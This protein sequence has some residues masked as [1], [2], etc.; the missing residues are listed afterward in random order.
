[1]SNQSSHPPPGVHVNAKRRL[2]LQEGEPERSQGASSPGRDYMRQTHV[3]SPAAAASPRTPS[4]HGGLASP[5]S[6][7]L[8]AAGSPSRVAADSTP[9]SARRKIGRDSPTEDFDGPTSGRFDTSL[10]ILTRKFV[11]LMTNAP[12]GVLD[13]NVA[14]N[15]LGVQKR[16]IYDI[17]NVL[18]G[19]GLL[20]K[21]SKNNIQWKGSSSSG[22]S[23]AMSAQADQLRE[24]IAALEAQDK[25]LED[26]MRL[27]QDNLR[28][29]AS[30]EHNVQLAYVTHED[31]RNI[32]SF[33]NKTLIAVKAP[34][35]TRLE[36]PDP[37]MGMAAGQRRYQILL[38]SNDGQ[39]DVFLVSRNH[40]V[41]PDDDTQAMVS[42]S[43]A[44]PPTSSS[45]A[46]KSS[47]SAPAQ[48]HEPAFGVAAPTAFN[49]PRGNRTRGASGA[50]SSS[51]AAPPATNGTH[52]DAAVDKASSEA[53]DAASAADLMPM[54]DT[55]RAAASWDDD[56]FDAQ[57]TQ[58]LGD[59]LIRTPFG[60]D[61][62]IPINPTGFSTDDYLFNLD[63]SE[64]ISNLYD[65]GAFDDINEP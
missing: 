27:M 43:S 7:A 62:L 11:D 17:T 44:P 3:G 48:K 59:A 29:L 2:D 47:S 1:M 13:L 63:E 56:N 36:V 38:K 32:E 12:G 33:R 49:S 14:A 60:F 18:E 42:E 52:A 58:Q 10:G 30:Q 40:D 8:A 37:D 20:E 15:M 45:A 53:A 65:F 46:P 5:V 21:R 19:I 35:G 39:I 9:K 57:A 24:D 6:A 31:I 51:A 64:G 41:V 28:R 16:R 61:G 34:Q 22:N 25:A 54:L 55:E 4:H 23:D 50:S 26:H